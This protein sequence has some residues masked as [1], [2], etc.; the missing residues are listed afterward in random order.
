MSKIPRSLPPC[1]LATLSIAATL[2]FAPLS[3]LVVAQS[4]FQANYDEDAVPDYELP[5]PL[6]F[7]DGSAVAGQGDWPK[8][9]AEILAL[10]E[11]H[12]YGRTPV[13]RPEGMR[14]ELRQR[15]DPFLDGKAVLEEVRIRFTDNDED[16]RIDLLVVKPKLPEGEKART[17]L[18]LNFAGNHTLHPATEISLPESWMRSRAEDRRDGLVVDDRAT[19]KGRGARVSRWPVEKIIDAGLAVASIYY[20]DIEP[21]FDGGFDQSVRSLFDP[22]ADDEWGAI[23]AWAWGLSRAM[24][25]LETDPQIDAARVGV[26]GHSRL[27][28]TSLWAGAQDERFALVISNNS[29]CGGAALSRRAFGETVG[30]INTAFPHWFCRNFRDYNENESAL[31]VD[32]HQLLALIAPRMVHVGSAEEDRWADP[33]GEFL[34]AYHAEPVW[35]LHGLGGLGVSEMPGIHEPVGDRVRFHL[36][37]GPHK[38][39]D[40]DWEQY[41]AAL[42][43]VP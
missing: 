3:G 38:V 6:V 15:I 41:I 7:E 26:F 19:E 11:E 25:Y 32:Q 10:F 18:T 28:K 8:R 29:G 37:A 13:G 39:I 9:R 34:S 33:R 23:G 43:A 30:R 42:L 1:H 17:F 20:G 16:P 22:P 12:V 4:G 35:R 14:F 36:R 24:D 2:A 40:Y 27:G 31:P 21:D 5:D